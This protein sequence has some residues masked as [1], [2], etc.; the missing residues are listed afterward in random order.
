MGFPIGTPQ[1]E[2]ARRMQVL[3]IEEEFDEFMGS[4]Y[5]SEN[6][7]KELADLVFVCY[8][9]ASLMGYD[10]DEAMSRV[11]VSNMSK[12]DDH[13]LPIRREDG[14]VLKGPNY[15]APDLSDLIPE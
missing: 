8:Q 11:Y 5:R 2:Q 9:F 15:Q 3:L 4:D 7:L 10:L 1:N 14:K 6:E 12:L 13:G